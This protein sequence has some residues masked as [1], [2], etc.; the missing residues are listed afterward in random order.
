MSSQQAA[1][2][3]SAGCYTCNGTYRF[4]SIG[5]LPVMN[6]IIAIYLLCGDIIECNTAIGAE[7]RIGIKICATVLTICH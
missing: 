7:V 1:Q 6:L 4:R 3:R 5:P 2:Q